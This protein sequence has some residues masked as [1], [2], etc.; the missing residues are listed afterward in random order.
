M[1]KINNNK[2]MNVMNVLSGGLEVPHGVW[3]FFLE[4]SEETGG[5]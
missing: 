4:V 3:K 2:I 1:T 5:I